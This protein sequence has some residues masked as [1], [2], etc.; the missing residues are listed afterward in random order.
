MVSQGTLTELPDNLQQPPKNVYFWSKGKW[1]PY[2][3]KVDYVEPGKEFGPDLAIAHELSQ[4]YPDQDIGLIKHAKGGTAIRLWQPRMPLLRGLFQK[5]DDAQKASGG[6]VAALFWMQGERDARFHEPAY[7]KK[8]RNLIQEVRRKS[9]QPE[10]PVIFGRISRIIPQRESTENIRQAQQQVADEMANVIMVDTD[11][12]ERKPEEITVNGKPTTLLAHYSSRGQIDLG[13]H[14]AQAYLKLASATVDDPQSHSLVK[15]LLKAEPNAQACCENAAQFEIA[16]V[17]LPYNPQGDN[18]H[19]GWPVATKSGDSLIVVHRA[20]PGHNVNVAGK[21]DADTTYS[22]IVR[23][24]DGGKK[25]STPY[26]IRNCMQ[27][28]DRNRGGMIPL[29]HR[30]KFGPKNLSPLGYK[31]HLN[32]VGT[33]RDGAVILVCNH[34]VFRSDDEGKSWRHLKTAFREDHHSGPIVYV[35]PRIIDDPKLGLLLFGHHTHYKNNRPGSIVRELALYQSKDGG[36]SWKNISIPLPDWCHQAE[37]NF[38]FHQGEFYGLARNQTTRNLIQMRGK[39]GAP[40]EVKETNMISK[41]SVDT[42][43]LIFNPVTGNF[44]AVQSDRSSM[45]INLF[46]IAPEKWETAVWKMEC[47]LFD[48][49][50]KFYE[51]ADGFHTGGSVV[52]LKTGV[53]HVFFYSGA[54]GGPAGV[55]RMTRPLKTTLLTTDR[56]TEIQK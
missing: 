26:D 4:A 38:V 56:Q 12:L 32:A 55:F 37:P 51:T 53:Q 40:I 13:T 41:R 15:R 1:V 34:G 21:A 27:A 30:Y 28:A 8:F 11:S 49:E 25:W 18:D 46:S 47:R 20:M 44:E 42:S 6:E 31:V 23:S 7:A 19:Y 14:L 24:T 16:P 10:L 3:N 22:V 52:D 9:D 29:S 43:D 45:S 2:H 17:N 48:R 39:P 5:L 33:T 36:E 50:G 54:P 35:G